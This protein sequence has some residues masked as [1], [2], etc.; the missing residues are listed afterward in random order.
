ML[1]YKG[2]GV[3]ASSTYPVTDCFDLLPF[4]TGA[5]GSQRQRLNHGLFGVFQTGPLLIP[6]GEAAVG[7]R[8]PFV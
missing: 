5:P 8:E 4:P 1:F 3:L 2:D 6:I 7:H